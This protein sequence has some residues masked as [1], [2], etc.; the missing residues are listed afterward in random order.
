[1]EIPYTVTARSDT[2]LWNAKMGIWLFLASEVMLFG[3]LFSSLIF[4]RISADYPWPYKVQDIPLGAINTVVLIASSVTVVL[5]WAALKMRQYRLFQLYMIATVLC[6]GVFMVNKYFEYSAK[7][8]HYSVKFKDGSAM[9]GHLPAGADGKH[10]WTV[11]DYIFGDVSEVEI[12]LMGGY[13]ASDLGWKRWISGGDWEIAGGTD[14]GEI[15]ASTLRSKRQEVESARADLGRRLRSARAEQAFAGGNQE[16]ASR[17]EDEIGE[18]EGRLASLPGN[19]VVT[20]EQPLEFKVPRR[21]VDS[22]SDTELRFKDGT[23]LRGQ[24]KR[25]SVR[26]VVDKIDLRQAKDPQDNKA[27]SYLKDSDPEA[28]LAYQTLRAERLS[29]FELKYPHYTNPLHPDPQIGNVEAR[30]KIL[31]PAMYDLD[32]ISGG[33]H[34]PKVEIPADEVQFYTNFSPRKNTYYSV[35]YLLTGLHGLHVVGGAIVLGYFGFF[36]RRLYDKNPEHLANRVE[37]G[38]LFW[39]FVDLVWIFLFPILYLF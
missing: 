17:I 9:E 35:Y 26:L 18:I 11:N 27:L 32:A 37:V 33:H 7:I 14:L 5:A 15:D 28:A 16:L 4:L 22:I 23:L 30:R 20:L 31:S 2:G 13:A 19:L 3:G 25:D 24:L 34:H 6:A 21:S 10:D 39:H 38:G 12:N 8:H 36:C 1:M 29:A